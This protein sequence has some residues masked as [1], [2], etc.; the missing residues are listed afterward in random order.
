MKPKKKWVLRLGEQEDEMNRKVTHEITEEQSEVKGKKEK[1]PR[2]RKD[3]L[4]EDKEKGEAKQIKRSKLVRR[5]QPRG[6]I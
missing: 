1:F 6:T 3:E 4:K 2:K 5:R